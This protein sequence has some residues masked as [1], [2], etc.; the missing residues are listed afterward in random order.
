MYTPV[1]RSSSSSGGG[2]GNINSNDND[3]DKSVAVASA[4][5]PPKGRLS[6]GP[7]SIS[8]LLSSSS[9]DLA[10]PPRNTV[11]NSSLPVLDGAYVSLGSDAAAHLDAGTNGKIKPRGDRAVTEPIDCA[12]ILSG[13][14]PSPASKDGRLAFTPDTA[15]RFLATNYSPTSSFPNPGLLQ[16]QPQQKECYSS[17]SLSPTV[18]TPHVFGDDVLLGIEELVINS[19]SS[20]N[21]LMVQEKIQEEEEEQECYQLQQQEHQHGGRQEEE[22]EEEQ[23]LME[24]E[25]IKRA[26]AMTQAKMDETVDVLAQACATSLKNQV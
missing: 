10:S 23:A 9:S 13:G 14:M 15:A 7:V 21:K 3:N 16:S 19:G 11:T 25:A 2:G 8:T 24:E 4:G 20:A 18:C 17:A 5:A 6:T 1:K 26:V 12:R 22:E